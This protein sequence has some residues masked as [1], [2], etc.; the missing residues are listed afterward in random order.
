MLEK[1]AVLP[2]RLISDAAIR[3]DLAALSQ[4]ITTTETDVTEVAKPVRPRHRVILDKTRLIYDGKTFYRGQKLFVQSM[5]YT[6]FPAIVYALADEYVHIRSRTPGDTREVFATIDD[7]RTGR[8]RIG[9]KIVN[10]P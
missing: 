8:V 3:E 2:G 5:S 10:S 4:C 6:R 1:R 9:R 7:L